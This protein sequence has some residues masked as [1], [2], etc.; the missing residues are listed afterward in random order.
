MRAL[1]FFSLCL[2]REVGRPKEH[3]K[4]GI[5]KARRDYKR[6][7]RRYKR[8]PWDTSIRGTEILP[9]TQDQPKLSL[10][11]I[12][13]HGHKRSPEQWDSDASSHLVVK[14]VVKAFSLYFRWVCMELEMEDVASTLASIK[15]P[16]R[17]EA[18]SES[19]SP[20]SSVPPKFSSLIA[21]IRFLFVQAWTDHT[22]ILWPVRT[23]ELWVFSLK[24]SF[25]E[26]RWLEEE[27][28]REAW[29]GFLALHCVS[30]HVC[31]MLL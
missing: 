5:K 6:E 23:D 15:K 14:V 17:E 8:K 3:R 22:L 24:K 28:R 7:R 9:C 16:W 29:Y 31:G 1:D 18:T 21:Q 11:D 27:F 26:E 4:E 30:M 13:S 25:K 20:P 10:R 12:Q 19:Q 2:T